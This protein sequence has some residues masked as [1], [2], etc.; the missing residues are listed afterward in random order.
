MN[1]FVLSLLSF[2]DPFYHCFI[3]FLLLTYHC[4]RFMF[5]IFYDLDSF[6]LLLSTTDNNYADFV[7]V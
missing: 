3:L 7:Y 1:F 5:A 4:Y 6:L 2:Y